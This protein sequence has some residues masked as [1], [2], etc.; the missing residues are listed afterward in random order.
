MLSLLHYHHVSSL[1]AVLGLDD[2]VVL[3][4]GE[5][6]WVPPVVVPSPAAAAAALSPVVVAVVLL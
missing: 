2:G 3:V 1:L 6:S 5:L 4:W